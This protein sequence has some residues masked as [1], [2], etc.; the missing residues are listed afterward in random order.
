V[1]RQQH[2]E[3]LALAAL[4]FGACGIGM[5][6][7]FVRLSPVGPVATAFWRLALACPVLFLWLALSPSSGE[8]APSRAK[9]HPLWLL[10]PG[11]FFAGDLAFWHWSIKLTSVA[12]ATVLTNC[13][14]VFV[15]LVAW[16]YFGE[17]IRFTFLLG[18]LAGF[19]GVLL[20]MRHSLTLSRDALLGDAFGLT[21]AGFYAGYQLSIKRL[22][23]HYSSAFVMTWSS[24]CSAVALAVITVVMGESFLWQEA[25]LYGAMIL[26]L[27]AL[28]SQVG[29]Q[30]AITYALAH[31]PA[32]FSSVALLVQP[33]VASI[34]AWL[35]LNERISLDQFFGGVILLFGIVLARR[36]ASERSQPPEVIS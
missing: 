23:A 27:L 3:R 30:G 16:R 33:L 17:R 11:L 12:N 7:I 36:G 10:V 5:A 6:P 26:V 19:A 1:T 13:A 25:L 15:T 18:L 22:R 14:P 35:L 20:L 4:I 8:A 21:T 9:P 29:G 34:A 28:V 24:F 31:L 32:S 2:I